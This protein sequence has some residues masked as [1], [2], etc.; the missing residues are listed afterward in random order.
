VLRIKTYVDRCE[1]AGSSGLPFPLT[2]ATV[3]Q[4]KNA[5]REDMQETMLTGLRLTTEG[6]SFS[7][8]S[9]RFNQDAKVIFAG[10]IEKMIGF[11]L[12][13]ISGDILR[14]TERGRLLG[15]QVFMEFVG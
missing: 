9:A 14:L 4:H 15:N 8:F 13:E 6:V 11:G 2:A 3:N 7:N 12:L 1:S 10:E 5:I